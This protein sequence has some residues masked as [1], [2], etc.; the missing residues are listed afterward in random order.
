MKGW[1]EKAEVEKECLGLLFLEKWPQRKTEDYESKFAYKS[2][3]TGYEEDVRLVS[4]AFFGM[5]NS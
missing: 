5:K 1:D 3:L 4:S 2:S